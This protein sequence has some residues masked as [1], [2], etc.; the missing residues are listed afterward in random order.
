MTIYQLLEADDEICQEVSPST[1]C[2]GGCKETLAGE[3]MV[4]KIF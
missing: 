2:H 1:Q 4:K 3:H